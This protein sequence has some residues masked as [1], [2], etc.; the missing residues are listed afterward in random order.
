LK[1][2]LSLLKILPT[3]LAHS[4]ALNGLKFLDKF[5]ILSFI[6]KEI[7]NNELELLGMKFKNNLGTAAGLDKNG[8]YI[9]SLG[10]LGFGFLEVG[11]VTPLPQSGNEKPRLFRVFNENA[12]I[13]RMG[14]NNK[15]VDHLVK[16]LKTHKYNG[17]VGV[18]IGANKSSEG[19]KRIDDYLE[20]FKKVYKYADYIVVNISSPNTKNL[21][22]LHS[23]ENLNMLLSEI[24]QL[25]GE[26]QNTKP[27]FLKISPD[28]N[29][30]S[31]KQIIKIVESSIFSGLIATN[32]TVDKTLLKESKYHNYEGG[33]SG[34]PL[35]NKSNE[36]LELINT[37]AEDMPLI[38]VGGVI[39]KET[40]F[41][42]LES[43]ADLVQIYTGFII[44]GPSI[45]SEI[46]N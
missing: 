9:N 36:K 41:K 27:I 42:K 10:K 38:A 2:A 33:L 26:L 29:D 40:Y 25:S 21:R 44:K 45:V 6:V 12:I 23:A 20:C 18:N 19:D 15:G 24:S 8:D 28:E 35:Y 22:E 39:N 11:T 17:I 46:L 13:N 5:G 43:G 16:N 34:T 4:L 14:F 31:L 3:E 7:K 32:T 37:I 30:E 1:L